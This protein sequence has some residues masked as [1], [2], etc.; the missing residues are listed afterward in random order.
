MKHIFY[1]HFIVILQGI[2]VFMMKSTISHVSP[3]TSMFGMVHHQ[4]ISAW[5]ENLLFSSRMQL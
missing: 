5:K 2:G 4:T 1:Q 3:K